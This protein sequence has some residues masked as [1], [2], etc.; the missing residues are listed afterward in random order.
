M[1]RV[2]ITTLCYLGVLLA[3]PQLSGIKEMLKT[4]PETQETAIWL[5]DT[6]FTFYR[7]DPT[8]TRQVAEL[9]LEKAIEW[10]AELGIA[11]ANHVI[12]VSYWAKDQYEEALTYYLE[13][14][15][16]YEALDIKKGIATIN[17]NI[18]TIYDDLD[19]SERGVPYMQ[20][21]IALIRALGDTVN[22]GRAL[23]NMAVLYSNIDETDSAK[24]YFTE[25]MAIRK[26][27]DDSAGVAQ[28]YN[29]IA[30]IFLDKEDEDMSE[31]DAREAYKY[32]VEALNYLREEKDVNLASIIYSNLGKTLMELGEMEKSKEYMLRGLDLA[33]Q[34]E[35][36]Y[37]EQL[38]YNYLSQYYARMNNY[39]RSLE[40][41]VKQV[42]LDKE[43]RSADITEQIDKLNIRFETEK[44]ERQLAELEREQAEARGTRNVIIISSIAIIIIIGLLLI[45]ANLKR[46]KDK[47]IAELTLKNLNDEIDKKNREISSYTLSFIQK[48]QLLDE[49][50]A[51]I[52]EMKNQS[53]NQI[54]KQLTR[55]NKIVD[56]TFRSDE[57]WKTFQ[58]TF[59]QMHDG[60][61]ATLKEQFPDLGNAELKL[62]ALLRLNM[63]LK[64]SAKILGISP[65]SVKT[66]RYRLRKK[67]GLQTEDNLVDFLMKF[68]KEQSLQES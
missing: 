55:I 53:D 52:N 36:K 13:A 48:N 30:D 12:G 8:I 28:T 59:E 11:K 5:C 15:T 19:E 49:L 17:L 63:N 10:E 14:L 51:Q 39:E 25:C 38:A 42:E 33:L 61:F 64:E 16:Y 32:L 60:F 68:E 66:A 41:Y 40:Y 23:N 57:E 9:A 24:A 46:R 6:A 31:P 56:E 20:K 47:Q 58:I 3:Y 2:V 44:K 37:R 62:C 26:A 45:S 21:S 67:F 1:K 35:S 18:G 22:L 34:I 27:L 4:K 29:N 54:N 50:K 65:D 7:Q 43:Q